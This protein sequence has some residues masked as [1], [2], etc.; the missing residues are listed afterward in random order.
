MNQNIPLKFIWVWYSK[1][2]EM[3]AELSSFGELF[4]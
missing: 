3:T 4:L 1:S 2:D